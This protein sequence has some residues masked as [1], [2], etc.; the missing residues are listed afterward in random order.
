MFRFLFYNLMF[1]SSSLLYYFSIFSIYLSVLSIILCL[2]RSFFQNSF[3]FL[4]L[5]FSTLFSYCGRYH[6]VYIQC[7]SSLFYYIDKC[8]P[9][10]FKSTVNLLFFFFSQDYQT[11]SVLILLSFCIDYIPQNNLHV[12]LSQMLLNC[13]EK[14]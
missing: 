14:E 6:F 13:H 12:D 2:S 4:N 10:F 9:F 1:L 11:F 5:S 3:F 7:F 8:L